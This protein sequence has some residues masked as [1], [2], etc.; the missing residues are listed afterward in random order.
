MIDKILAGIAALALL[1]VVAIIGYDEYSKQEMTVIVELKQGE[2][3]FVAIRHIVPMDS[4][5]K[6]VREIDRSKNEYSMI[7]TTKRKR[8]ALLE[9]F[10]NSH[11]VENVQI[12]EEE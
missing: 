9:W 5:I 4:S 3:P 12:N 10:N 11:R 2:D 7:V 6:E 8:K 1:V